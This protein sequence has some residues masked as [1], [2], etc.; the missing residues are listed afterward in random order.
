VS[1][2]QAST[3]SLD[4][5]AN[6][7]LIIAHWLSKKLLFA[8]R[9]LLLSSMLYSLQ[10]YWSSMFILPKKT[11]RTIEQKFNRFLW[12]GNEVSAARAKVAWEVLCVPKN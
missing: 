11:I 5:M 6:P 12:S 1:S 8:R 9:L 4:C 3:R 7:G 2:F 10:V